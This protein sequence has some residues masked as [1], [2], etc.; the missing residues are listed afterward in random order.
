[1]F[2]ILFRITKNIQKD[3]VAD[4]S[5]LT[6]QCKILNVEGNGFDFTR[7][8]SFDDFVKGVKVWNQST[9]ATLLTI[10]ADCSAKSVQEVNENFQKNN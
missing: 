9:G 5:G 10:Q 8:R 4:Q 2:Q 1:M 7:D 6:A 3:G